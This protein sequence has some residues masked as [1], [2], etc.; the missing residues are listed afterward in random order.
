VAYARSDANA[1]S[2]SN[3]SSLR[4][5]ASV[6]SQEGATAQDLRTTAQAV[7]SPAVDLPCEPHGR[8]PRAMKKRGDSP[9]VFYCRMASCAANPVSGTFTIHDSQCWQISST[10]SV[11][12]TNGTVRLG[13]ERMP[14]RCCQPG[15]RHEWHCTL[16]VNCF[17]QTSY[18]PCRAS[19]AVC[20]GVP[21]SACT[22]PSGA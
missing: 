19:V 3:S 1:R 21:S 7:G 8:T 6:F 13:S 16:C 17:T 20:L 15:A 5:P 4:L 2:S 9:R 12:G 11:P 14:I 22:G 18:L 10:R